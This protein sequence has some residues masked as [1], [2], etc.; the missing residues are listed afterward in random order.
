MWTHL[1][2]TQEYACWVI[3]HAYLLVVCW[4]SKSK[5]FAMI[6]SRNSV[7]IFYSSLACT[8]SKLLKPTFDSYFAFFFKK[9][10]TFIK[11]VGEEGNKFD[12]AMQLNQHWPIIVHS[13]LLSKL[14]KLVNMYWSRKMVS[15]QIYAIL[16]WELSGRVLDSR[17]RSRW[18]KP[19]RRHCF[20]SLSK[21]H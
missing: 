20:V 9:Y 2:H 18:F 17:L 6:I 8:K 21:T 5:L 3:L 19:H 12:T 1:K 16:K 10:L 14:L 4:L 15:A 7:F 11:G 13:K